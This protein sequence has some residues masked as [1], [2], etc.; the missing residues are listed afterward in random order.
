MCCHTTVQNTHT[1]V[2]SVADVYS[3]RIKD[4]RNTRN[5]VIA[6]V[7]TVKRV[8]CVVNPSPMTA[9]SNSTYRSTQINAHSPVTNVA[10]I[11]SSS[12]A[13][14]L[15]PVY[16]KFIHSLRTHTCVQQV[17]PQP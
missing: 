13:L 6:A 15:T 16:Y 12:T 8:R 7:R 14:G 17:H 3:S 4:I 2:L 11:T 9:V 10:R 1:S 5:S